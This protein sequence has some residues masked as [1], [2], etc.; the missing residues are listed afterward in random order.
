[1]KTKRYKRYKSARSLKHNKDFLCPGAELY[2]SIDEAL[3]SCKAN[4]HIYIIGG[5]GI[6]QQTI[7]IADELCLTEIDDI[8][9]KTDAFFPEIDLNI[10]YEKSRDSQ[11]VD[12]KHPCSYA[13]VDY[14]RR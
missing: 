5:E 13:F 2:T 10:W 3:Q 4:E 11:S 7:G 8:A 14:A 9:D 12:E 6:Y 1:M